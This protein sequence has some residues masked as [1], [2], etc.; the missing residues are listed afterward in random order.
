VAPPACHICGIF[1]SRRK[2]GE[3]I[4]VF[5]DI[6][7]SYHFI[8]YFKNK[9]RSMAEGILLQPQSL[10][11]PFPDFLTYWNHNLSYLPGKMGH[12][13]VDLRPARESPLLNHLEALVAL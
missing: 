12:A 13:Q 2:V 11:L 1:C 3:F 4:F 10:Y 6:L 5:K 7:L 8:L 9:K